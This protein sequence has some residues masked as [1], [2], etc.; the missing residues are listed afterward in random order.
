MAMV[1]QIPQPALAAIG[2]DGLNA[3]K[4]VEVRSKQVAA[5]RHVV[6]PR[7]IDPRRDRQAEDLDENAALRADRAP[8]TAAVVVE[9]RSGPPTLLG[10]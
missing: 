1:G 3:R 10:S 4:S 6:G 9:R 8:A 5:G 7:V 2:D